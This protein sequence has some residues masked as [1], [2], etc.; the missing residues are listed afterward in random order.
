MTAQGITTGTEAIRKITIPA[1]LLRLEGLV[2][3]IAALAVYFMQ[4]LSW[5]ALVALIAVP[6]LAILAYA[7]NKRVGALAY[8]TVHNYALP[9]ALGLL[10]LYAEWSV[11]WQVALIWVAHISVDR[12]LGF[13]L[14]Y[15][16]GFK[17]THL[18]RV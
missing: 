14:K 3:L 16:T 4:G 15:T 2:L 1:A 11:G 12:V 13:G 17:D 18:N 5:I 6:D 8:N 9:L 7:L 10:A